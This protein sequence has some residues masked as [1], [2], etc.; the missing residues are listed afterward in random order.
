MK[1][2]LRWVANAVAFYLALYLLDSLA[3]PRFWVQAVWA[4]VVLAVILALV[5]SLIRP[6]HRLRSRPYRALTMVVFTLAINALVLQAFVWIGARLST[7]SPIWVLVAAVFLAVVG[8]LINWLIGFRP[9]EKPGAVS[10]ERRASQAGAREARATRTR[11]G[12]GPAT[13]PRR[14]PGRSREER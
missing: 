5:N 4:A 8:G 10:R 1:F 13:N 6:L 11:D 7:T 9:K 14:Q 3:T 2:M 12:R